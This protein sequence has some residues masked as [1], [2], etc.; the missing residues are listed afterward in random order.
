MNNVLRLNM[1]E[2]VIQALIGVCTDIPMILKL[3]FIS[4]ASLAFS[5]SRLSILG[6]IRVNGSDNTINTTNS[7]IRL[8]RSRIN[9]YI[10]RV[11][12]CGYKSLATACVKHWCRGCLTTHGFAGNKCDCKDCYRDGQ[13]NT[14]R[15]CLRYFKCVSCDAH[16]SRENIIEIIYAGNITNT[17]SEKICRNCAC[18]CRQCGFKTDLITNCMHFIEDKYPWITSVADHKVMMMC[19]EC[20]DS[21]KD[22]SENIYIKSYN[23]GVSSFRF[24]LV[25][26]KIAAI[27]GIEVSI[28]YSSSS[29]DS[30][31]ESDSDSDSESESTSTSSSSDSDF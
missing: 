14:Y 12:G 27:T 29:S 13:R 22:N 30:S 16:T 28:S 26:Q 6:E 1:S 2:E 31:D 25:E 15:Y 9:K 11:P 8:F 18:R 21:S 24:S 17:H 4:K 3:G 19:N 23:F 7:Q 20:A 5:I 10:C